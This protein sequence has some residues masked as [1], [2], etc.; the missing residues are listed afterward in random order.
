MSWGDH[1]NE[2]INKKLRIAER[3][4]NSKTDENLQNSEWNGDEF[5]HGDNALIDWGDGNQSSCRVVSWSEKYGGWWYVQ[6]KNGTMHYTQ[7]LIK[8]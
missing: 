5:K 2:E 8:M 6:L 1:D 4:D 3:L 7:N